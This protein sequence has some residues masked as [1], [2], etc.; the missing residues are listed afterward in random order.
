MLDVLVPEPSQ[1]GDRDRGRGV[2]LRGAL[3][4][5]RAP[6]PVRSG[7]KAVEHHPVSQP[8]LPVDMDQQ[9]PVQCFGP[10]RSLVLPAWSKPHSPRSVCRNCMLE[11]GNGL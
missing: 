3:L 6:Y 2:A 10:D 9:Q 11:T 8:P 1:I 5:Q 7:S 4:R